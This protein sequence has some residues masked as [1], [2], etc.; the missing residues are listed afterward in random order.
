MKGANARDLRKLSGKELDDRLDELRNTLLHEK[1]STKTRP[2]KK[3]I[4][5]ILTIKNQNDRK[6]VTSPTCPTDKGHLF[7]TK[8]KS[9]FQIGSKN[10]TQFGN[11]LKYKKTKKIEVKKVG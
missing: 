3:A 5:R 1:K 2:V 10:Q 11:E 4:A 9:L 6:A 7:G 8:P